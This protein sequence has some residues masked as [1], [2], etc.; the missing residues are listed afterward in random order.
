MDTDGDHTV[1]KQAKRPAKENAQRVE[2][3]SPRPFQSGVFDLDSGLQT[4]TSLVP[5]S[6]AGVQDAAVRA[7]DAIVGH[8]ARA[9]RNRSPTAKEIAIHD[10]VTA[11]IANCRASVDVCHGLPAVMLIK[12]VSSRYWYWAYGWLVCQSQNVIITGNVHVSGK[13]SVRACF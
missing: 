10:R 12:E 8:M 3:Q 6:A 13:V 5:L 4:Q 9:S 7:L 2:D 1:R 11:C